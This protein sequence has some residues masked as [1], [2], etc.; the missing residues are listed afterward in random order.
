MTTVEEVLRRHG[1]TTTEDDIAQRLDILLTGERRA[2][3][4]LDL[5]SIEQDFLGGHGG[6]EPVTD[7]QLADLDARSNARLTAEATMSLS[8]SQIAELLEVVPSRI[9]HQ[10]AAGKLYSYLGSGRRP[11]FPDWQITV[12]GAGLADRSTS[13]AHLVPHLPD[14]IQAM[15]ADAHPVA[16]RAFMTTPTQSL[17]SGDGGA[18][19]PVEWLFSGGGAGPIAEMAATL[20]EQV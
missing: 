8:R 6:V 14:V 12:A 15:P 11:M 13:K 19:S 17:T 10:V 4:A 3:T 2:D 20:G 5:T 16:V 9:S 7:R 18:M 1:Y